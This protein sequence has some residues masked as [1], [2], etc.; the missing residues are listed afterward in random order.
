MDT[1][2]G[3][4]SDLEPC[5]YLFV[6][7]V[8]HPYGGYPAWLVAYGWSLVAVLVFVLPLS[9]FN[10]SPGTLHLIGSKNGSAADANGCSTTRGGVTVE[11]NEAKLDDAAVLSDL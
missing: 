8:I 2:L 6:D 1:G 11:L 7:D 9:L 10:K 3:L 4:N 5:R